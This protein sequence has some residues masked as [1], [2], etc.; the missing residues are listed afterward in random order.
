MADTDIDE[1]DLDL[2]D[3]STVIPSPAVHSKPPGVLPAW[4]NRMKISVRT[5]IY[6]PH[7]AGPNPSNPAEA[8]YRVMLI[9]VLDNPR[10]EGEKVI[11]RVQVDAKREFDNRLYFPSD[12]TLISG[13]ASWGVDITDEIMYLGNAKFWCGGIVFQFS[14]RRAVNGDNAV[15]KETLREEFAW[16]VAVEVDLGTLEGIVAKAGPVKAREMK[17]GQWRDETGREVKR[18]LRPE[19][20]IF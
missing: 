15:I 14:S 18:E 6:S 5:E 7:P 12:V 4:L 2:E 3:W 10:L 17:V 8:Y 1:H 13:D 19:M 11:W 20:F 9:D 16:L